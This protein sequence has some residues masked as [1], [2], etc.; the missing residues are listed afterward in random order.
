MTDFAISP[1]FPLEEARDWIGRWKD[2]G[3]GFF[4]RA[5]AGE[6]QVQLAFQG[7]S[8]IMPQE[9]VDLQTELLTAPRLKSAVTSLVA[10]AWAK[11]NIAA[12]T[13]AGHA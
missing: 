5:E 11:A 3:G 10:D 12:G 6:V 9:A 4:C 1:A 7:A 8:E 2:A 13:P